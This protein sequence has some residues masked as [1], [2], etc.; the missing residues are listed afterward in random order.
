[1][2]AHPYVEAAVSREL[3]ALRGTCEGGRGLEAYKAAASLGGWVGAGALGENEAEAMLLDAALATGMSESRAASNIRRGLQAGM[4]TPRVLPASVQTSPQAPPRA[5][6]RP[7]L[8]SN[9]F[10]TQG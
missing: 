7:S 5:V 6:S 1:M 10:F 2:I 9:M 8:T 3:E 4:A